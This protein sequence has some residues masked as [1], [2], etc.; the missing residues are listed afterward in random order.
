M[1]DLIAFLG[2][3]L[4]ETAARAW[5][6]HDVERCDALLYEE[7]MGAAAARTPEC[8]CGCS[9]RVLR[10][11]GAMRELIT[12]ALEN[13]A[14]I[15]GEWGDCHEAAEIASGLCA[16]HGV[17][18]AGRG[19]GLLAA[20]WRDHPDFRQEWA[21]SGGAVLRSRLPPRYL[22]A[23]LSAMNSVKLP[24][25]S[26]NLAP[27]EKARVKALGVPLRTVILTGLDVLERER[28]GSGEA[29]ASV[30]ADQ[31]AMVR[32]MVAAEV[33]RR[34]RECESGAGGEK[35]LRTARKR[36]AAPVRHA[37]PAAASS[38]DPVPVRFQ[39]GT[40]PAR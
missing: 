38:G 28:A 5:A 22:S 6:V 25:T 23:T 1:K 10:G 40:E 32:A 31:A 4:D 21:P 16:D 36:A 8:D 13:A 12:Y 34:L 3:R 15:D 39:P 35:G 20:I 17:K 9:A 33:D 37:V 19:L 7:D 2:A 24:P 11:V 14:M 27:E 26:V 30:Y 18:A 29:A